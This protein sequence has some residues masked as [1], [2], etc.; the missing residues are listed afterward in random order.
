METLL[1]LTYLSICWI[2]FKVFKIPVNKWSMTTVVLGGVILLGVIL[3]AMAYYHPASVSA[4]SYFISTPIVSNVKG[5]VISVD[6]IPNKLL[7]KNDI[8]FK[9][10]P[11]P[12]QAVV[13][14]LSAQLEFSKT[15][16]DDS[17]KLNKL[18][19][20][21]KF[22]I[23]NYAKEVNSL[24]AKL[25]KAKFDLESC[26]VKAP[27][28][29]YVTQVRARVGQ[30]AVPLP[31]LP[32]MTFIPAETKYLIA[33]FTQE[34][35]QNLKAGNEAEIIFSGIPGGIFHG[36]IIQILP[37]LAEGEISPT[38]TMVSLSRSLRRGQIPVMIEIT[39]DM[40]KYNMPMGIDA[41]VA[42][43]SEGNIVHHIAI[44]RKVLLR[45]ESWK[46]FLRFH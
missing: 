13:N 24:K 23:Q 4:R 46:N 43:Y 34:P 19:G 6:A 15:R 2:V 12:F 16:L 26:V 21:S 5:K 10:D 9:I 37:A 1:I 22:D 41:S 40:S 30:M 33:G 14:D 31:L 27:S 7:N 44:I 38:Q 18:A 11:T 35:M 3:M 29:G 25:E 8:L 20:G 36:K 17:I 42:V 45:M 39:D 28:K 32:V